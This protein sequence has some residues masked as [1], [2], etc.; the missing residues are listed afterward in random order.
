MPKYPEMVIF[1][2]QKSDSK[3]ILGTINDNIFYIYRDVDEDY[4]LEIYNDQTKSQKTI[5]VTNKKLQFLKYNNQIVLKILDNNSLKTERMLGTSSSTDIK[6]KYLSESGKYIS[7]NSL[8][9]VKGVSNGFK[10]IVVNGNYART[11]ESYITYSLEDLYHAL[12][13]YSESASLK[14]IF[15]DSRMK[16]K[17]SG[18]VF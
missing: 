8:K 16:G 9:V 18:R 6:S 11:L 2:T 5:L 1:G 12:S 7:L 15:N 13:N 14:E 4:A 17:Y 10:P 3:F